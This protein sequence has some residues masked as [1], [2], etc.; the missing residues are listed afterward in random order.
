MGNGLVNVRD[1]KF[2]LFEQLGI[3]KLFNS[4][5][6]G[7]YTND[8]A[9]ML[10]GEAEKLA[11][12]EM[13]PTYAEGD[14]EGCTL[15]DGKVKVPSCFH[16]VYKKICEAGWNC[17]SRDPE[18]GGQGMPL[19]LFTAC[20]E[21]FNAANFP[22]MM[23]PGLTVG[24]AALI[25][26]FGTDEQRQKYMEKMYS[27]E[28]GGTMG[29]TEPGAGSD[30]GALRTKAVKQADGTYLIT[31][32]KMFI[33]SGD[34]DLTSNNIHAVLAR[35]EGDPAGTDGIS[36]F[37]VPKIKVNDDGS[38]GEP[39][40]VITGNIEHK[41]GIKGSATC[42]LNFGEEEKCYGELLG[43]ERQGMEIMFHMMN[44]ARLEVGIQGLGVATAAFE[45]ARDYARERVQS[46]AIWDMTNPEAKPVTIIEHPDIR[47]TLLW[48]KSYLEGLRA[49]NYYV[50]FAFDRAE[51]ATED[52]DRERW[53]A[54]VEL[55]TP[56]CK[57]FST[58][59]A[60]EIC[61]YAI[62]IYG[63]YGYCSEYPVEQYLRDAKITTIYE[64]TNGIQSLDL[65]GRKLAQNR[66]ENLKSM[67]VEI[68]KTAASAG[69]DPEL[70]LLGAS[71]GKA[72]EAVGGVTMQF[73]DWADGA[74]MVLAILNARPFLEVLG[75][76][77][78]GWQLVHGAQVASAALQK[79][80]AEAGAESQAE[81]RA[82]ARNSS[83][84]A[85]YEGKIASATYFASTILPTVKGRC[86]GIQ[87][88]DR[89]PIE[90]L[91][92]SFG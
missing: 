88:G 6:Y 78:V 25:E 66:G 51:I 19:L 30:V 46:R 50:A 82:F 49:L 87:A 58:D 13:E 35:I 3:D 28:F 1:Q 37:I 56:V 20:A 24:A 55:L 71:L 47:R 10:L 8:D 22:L 5:K 73:K 26:K 72:A 52:A 59:K 80:Y 81:R 36:I 60:M 27:G 33:S 79:I 45:H 89:T 38:L 84:A 14:K 23:Y 21:L 31:G 48:M 17:A 64:G 9:N 7:D 12:N 16:D 69:A 34:H 91:D 44:E 85:F 70:Q 2:I 75:D 65:V 90:M 74:G 43:R 68:G 54:V 18:V 77:L 39:N 83:E 61:S 67:F 62:D 92:A 63:G 53:T 76:V 15:I 57:A 11:V 4:E 41:M 32:T 40:D 42:T 86:L 29:L